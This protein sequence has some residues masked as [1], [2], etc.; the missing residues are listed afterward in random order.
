MVVVFPSPFCWLL[1]RV[2]HTFGGVR[3]A[4]L[5]GGTRLGPFWGFIGK[6]GFLLVGF[7]ATLFLCDVANKDDKGASSSV[8][9]TSVR[10]FSS[11]VYLSGKWKVR[12]ERK[13]EGRAERRSEGWGDR[14]EKYKGER[15]GERKYV[16]NISLRHCSLCVMCLFQILSSP[17]ST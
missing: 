2:E 8:C 11:S 17:T 12:R 13:A 1:V 9:T 16:P 5:V 14:E 10:S 7:V 6:L 15:K 3:G 4:G